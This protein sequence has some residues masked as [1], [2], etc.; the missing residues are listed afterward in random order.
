LHDK[1]TAQTPYANYR[2]VP[3]STVQFAAPSRAACSRQ[4]RLDQSLTESTIANKSAFERPFVQE[5]YCSKHSCLHS[6][7]RQRQI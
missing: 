6:Y 7:R 5:I 1:L 3:A 2:A 4:S